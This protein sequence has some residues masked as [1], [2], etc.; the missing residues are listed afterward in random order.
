M[1]VNLSVIRYVLYRTD[2]LHFASQPR[3]RFV[4][5]RAPLEAFE[6][7]GTE[8]MRLL[9]AQINALELDHHLTAKEVHNCERRRKRIRKLIERLREFRTYRMA[10]LIGS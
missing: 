3:T 1:R 6:E 5:G 4:R 9:Q 2:L 10:C 7:L 8:I